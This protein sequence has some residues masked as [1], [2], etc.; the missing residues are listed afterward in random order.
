MVA[1]AR[2]PDI[3]VLFIDTAKGSC[4]NELD[5][6]ILPSEEFL[7]LKCRDFDYKSMEKVAFY[8]PHLLKKVKYF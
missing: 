5:D 3:I 8:P 2:N 4:V 1:I 7:G 6:A